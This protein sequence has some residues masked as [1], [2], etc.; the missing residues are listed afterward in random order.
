MTDLI[1]NRLQF[2]F[3]NLPDVIQPAQLVFINFERNVLDEGGTT[4]LLE[5][6]RLLVARIDGSRDGD[7]PQRVEIG[8]SLQVRGSTP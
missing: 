2:M 1:G 8:W 5:A 7:G 4:D 6:V 3:A